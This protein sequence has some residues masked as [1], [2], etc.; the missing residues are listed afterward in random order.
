MTVDDKEQP[1]P[2]SKPAV[3]QEEKEKSQS[4]PSFHG[5]MGVDSGGWVQVDRTSLELEWPTLLSQLPDQIGVHTKPTYPQVSEYMKDIHP[6]IQAMFDAFYDISDSD[7]IRSSTVKDFSNRDITILSI[8]SHS[9]FA[10]EQLEQLKQEDLVALNLL[11]LYIIVLWEYYNEQSNYEMYVDSVARDLEQL[12]NEFE[13]IKTSDPTQAQALREIGLQT[14][15]MP[16]ALTD[17]GRI[18]VTLLILVLIRLK[19]V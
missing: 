9:F 11:S 3:S 10:E 7:W 8:Y 15:C 5:P 18:P 16:Q 13:N 19:A 12:W 4:D 1:R 2:A 6:V 14:G 17:P